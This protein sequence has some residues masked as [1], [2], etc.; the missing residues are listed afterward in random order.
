MPI[1]SIVARQNA[2]A[3]AESSSRLTQ[4]VVIVRETSTTSVQC[5]SDNRPLIWRATVKYRSLSL[6]LVPPV[7]RVCGAT[8]ERAHQWQL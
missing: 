3:T 2:S 4:S 8:V 6:P 1:E 7:S 5:R